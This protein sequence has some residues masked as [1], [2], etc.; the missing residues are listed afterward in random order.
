M[1]RREILSMAA[2]APAWVSVARMHAQK[3]GS[4]KMGGTPSAFSL[5]A[6]GGGGA[7]PFDIV[8]HCHKIGLGGVQTSL[9]A[10]ELELAAK[11]DKRIK[12]YGMELVLDAPPLP[13]EEG[14]LY[15]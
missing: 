11:L 4:S 15:R 2:S 5:R 14:Q 8:E 7:T 1:T 13:V 10:I 12:A 9:E 3:N 6:Q